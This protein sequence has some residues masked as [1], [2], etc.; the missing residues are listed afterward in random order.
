MVLPPAVHKPSL[1]KSVAGRICRFVAAD[2]YFNLPASDA[3]AFI[4]KFLIPDLICSPHAKRPLPETLRPSAAVLGA[5]DDQISWF[6]TAP[7][8]QA[9]DRTVAPLLA[10]IRANLHQSRTLATLRDTL[11]P[12][13][14]SGDLR[15][16][17]Y[18]NAEIE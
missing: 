9:F 8:T 18:Y 7:L 13:L 16:K 10:L 17:I 12:K 6:P 15:P 3:F 14:L 4:A 2:A 5:L 1:K 11:L